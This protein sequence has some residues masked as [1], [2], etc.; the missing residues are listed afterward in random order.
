VA[1]FAGRVAVAAV[2]LPVDDDAAADAGAHE[3]AD[4]MAGF[5]FQFGDIDTQR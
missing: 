3:N 4:H 5:G 1:D 2:K